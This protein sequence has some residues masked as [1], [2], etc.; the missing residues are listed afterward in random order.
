[1]RALGIASRRIGGLRAANLRVAAA[2][3]R[4]YATPVP[5]ESQKEDPQLSDFGYPEVPTSS[6]GWRSAR[7]WQDPQMRRNYEE[8]L[9]FEEE[10]YSMWGPDVP[11][12]PPE[13]ALRQFT[14]VALGFVAFGFLCKAIVPD[15]PAVPRQY[16]FSG[17]EAE[18][19]GVKAQPESIEEDEE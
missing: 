8:P 6:K 10:L 14:F 16:P 17:L 19:G 18:L 2:S 1:M 5:S 9:H 3:I 4:T 12:V 13:Q 7:G 15:R 11:V